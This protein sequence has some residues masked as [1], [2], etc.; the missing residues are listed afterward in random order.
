MHCCLHP[1]SPLTVANNP[2][3]PTA[4]RHMLGA[5]HRPCI[6]SRP[7]KCSL[8]TTEC[9]DFSSLSFRLIICNQLPLLACHRSTMPTTGQQQMLGRL[10]PWQSYKVCP[11]HSAYSASGMFPT[12]QAN[13]SGRPNSSILH[14]THPAGGA[15]SLAFSDGLA[16]AT[17]LYN[18]VAVDTVIQSVCWL[19]W[20]A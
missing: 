4:G 5:N 14:H 15:A 9:K 2:A 12:H 7:G 13:T 20:D 11:F 6:V 17:K 16:R 19:G 8:P 18:A 1:C 3:G 10:W